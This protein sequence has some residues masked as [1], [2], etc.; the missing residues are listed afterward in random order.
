MSHRNVRGRGVALITGCSSGF[1][2]LT[3]V[4][5]GSAGFRVYATMR[6]LSKRHRLDAAATAAGVSLTVLPLDVTQDESIQGALAT[7]R[8]QAGRID[9]LVSNAGYGLGGFV[10]DVTLAELRA[11]FEI[12]FFGAVALVK[13]VLPDMRRRG[14]GQI[15]LVS[16]L[17]GVQAM[18]GLA[19]Y[20]ASKFALEGFAEA[21]RWEALLD[22]VT[23]S[24]VEPGTFPTEIFGANRQIAA[25][26][27]DPSGPHYA[28]SQR[29]ERLVL[30][31]AARSKQDPRA[32]ARTIRRIATTRH[33]RLHYL[34]GQDAVLTVLARRFLPDW[35]FDALML[36]I[37]H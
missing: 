35:V 32:V 10:E 37:L 7:I 33:P 18:P 27:Q 11:Q 22:G 16:S 2:L 6:N 26:A 4:E 28:R 36:R 31:Y 12:N 3:A 14:R 30:Q 29:L 34:V 23:V 5:L 8:A 20:C 9:V 1:G 13:A 25:A 24:L 21:L 15:V 19:A 17:N